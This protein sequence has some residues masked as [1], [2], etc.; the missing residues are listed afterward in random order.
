VLLGI[1]LSIQDMNFLKEKYNTKD[2]YDCGKIIEKEFP[3]LEVFLTQP[4]TQ[5][6]DEW[7]EQEKEFFEEEDDPSFCIIG[8]NLDGKNSDILSYNEIDPKKVCI[9]KVSQQLKKLFGKKREVK[10]ILGGTY[11]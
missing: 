6:N 11:C 2:M 9:N 7:Y 1:K 8:Q 10:L 4:F 3:N 5:F